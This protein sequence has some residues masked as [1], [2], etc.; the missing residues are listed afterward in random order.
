[1]N[2]QEVLHQAIAAVLEDRTEEAE[3]AFKKHLVEYSGSPR[4]TLKNHVYNLTMTC[5]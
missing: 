3:S 1:M 4:E 2:P 5:V